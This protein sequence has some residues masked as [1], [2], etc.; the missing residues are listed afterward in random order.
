MEIVVVF[1]L[2]GSGKTFVGNILKKAFGFSL[3]EA[4]SDLP[5]DMREA[6]ATQSV[7]S[8]T[9]RDVFFAKI[10]AH[11][12]HLQKQQTKLVVTQTFIKEK[13]RK[14]F[15]EAF[16]NT[17]FLLVEAPAKLRERRL[18]NRIDY[19]LDLSYVQQMNTLFEAPHIPH[20][21]VQNDHEGETHIKKKLEEI[22]QR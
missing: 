15:L 22:L 4:D 3:H 8:D 10:V 17:L 18:K 5:D 13:Y 2:P 19:P 20:E 14:K 11:T 12:K 21:I 7:I 16:P 6:I 9:S 1:G